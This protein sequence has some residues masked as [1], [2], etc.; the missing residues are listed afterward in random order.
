[1][2]KQEYLSHQKAFNSLRLET[3]RL[4]IREYCE[5]NG[6][7]YNTARRHIKLNQFNLSHHS[8]SPYGSAA[9]NKKH[10]W[11]VLLERY[12]ISSIHD[13]DIFP[14]DF[15]KSHDIPYSIL[16]RNFSSLKTNPEISGLWEL[17]FRQ[18]ALL[19][20]LKLNDISLVHFEKQRR[21]ILSELNDELALCRLTNVE[22]FKD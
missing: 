8:T 7:H 16:R 21:A 22:D 17:H 11:P 10:N 1:M 15:A 14:I 9:E 4:T 5:Q 20:S 6:M 18:K 13:P 19:K 12:L 2:T 3:P